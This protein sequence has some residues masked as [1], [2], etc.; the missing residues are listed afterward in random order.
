MPL[1]ALSNCHAF[2]ASLSFKLLQTMSLLAFDVPTLAREIAGPSVMRGVLHMHA[3]LPSH[4]QA[5]ALAVIG[6]A[7]QWG[8]NSSLASAGG[9][10]TLGDDVFRV[11]AMHLDHPDALASLHALCEAAPL[12]A[13]TLATSSLVSLL[14]QPHHWQTLTAQVQT[15]PPD[16]SPGLLTAHSLS[17]MHC[18]L[19]SQWENVARSVGSHE[20]L[21]AALASVWVRAHVS[22]VMRAHALALAAAAA[23]GPAADIVLRSF[24][25]N[26]SLAE[27]AA[28]V[29]V[30]WEYAGANAGDR[31]ASAMQLI[32]LRHAT[33]L[34]VSLCGGSASAATAGAQLSLPSPS[35]STARSVL[36]ESMLTPQLTHAT[37]LL[38][39]SPNDAIKSHAVSI[40]RAFATAS[41]RNKQRFMSG[42]ALSALI[43]ASVSGQHAVRAA[44]VEALAVLLLPSG[45]D[46]AASS[47]EA[48]HVDSVAAAAA[49]DQMDA[50]MSA[51]VSAASSGDLLVASA[52]PLLHHAV[53]A[54]DAVGQ[55]VAR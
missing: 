45:E 12:R 5:V 30:S 55:F 28:A 1:F 16:V 40:I 52:L 37:L 36:S 44:A 42:G 18:M 17:L 29:I 35:S 21:L 3:Q 15:L 23:A 43:G 51:L 22:A 9:D 46:A 4:Q 53:V 24:E 31:T 2:S 41:A 54:L 13:H 25:G 7:V 38:L 48:A 49:R 27:A 20:T 32:V 33:T 8:A 6:I 47:A 10:S 26:H 50:L 14:L 39:P 11:L 34:L 19:H